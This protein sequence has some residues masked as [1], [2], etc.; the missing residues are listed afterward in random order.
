ML[1]GIEGKDFGPKIFLG[2]DI[3]VLEGQISGGLF[4]ESIFDPFVIGAKLH[5][6]AL[7]LSHLMK[8][9]SKRRRKKASTYLGFCKKYKRKESKVKLI[10]LKTKPFLGFCVIIR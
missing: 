3:G 1:V 5:P 6:G 9:K 10:L 8:K 2:S 4:S 7:Q